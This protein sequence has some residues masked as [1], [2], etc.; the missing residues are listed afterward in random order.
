MKQH[1]GG[2]DPFHRGDIAV[3]LRRCRNDTGAGEMVQGLE[4]QGDGAGNGA[5]RGSNN[6]TKIL[7]MNK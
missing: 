2:R 3:M 6:L 1:L 5:P 7:C 4:R